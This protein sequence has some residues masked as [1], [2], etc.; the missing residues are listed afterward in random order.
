VAQGLLGKWLFHWECP[1]AGFSLPLG[2]AEV[3]GTGEAG[4]GL[5]LPG[6]SPSELHVR[7]KVRRASF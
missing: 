5:F 6:K 4:L 7:A 1:D 2:S 3:A